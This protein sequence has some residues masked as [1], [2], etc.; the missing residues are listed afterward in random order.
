MGWLL[1]AV[2]KADRWLPEEKKFYH[3]FSIVKYSYLPTDT[4]RK[5]RVSQ[6]KVGSQKISNCS[7]SLNFEAKINCNTI[8]PNVPKWR[9][10]CTGL[11]FDLLD[12]YG[13][14][15]NIHTF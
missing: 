11:K 7:N 13:P 3:Q 5:Y 6:K 1:W 10:T 15:S 14:Q 2:A 8:K 4:F 12:F 9:K